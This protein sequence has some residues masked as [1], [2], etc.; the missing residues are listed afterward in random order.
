[1]GFFDD[2]YGG[3]TIYTGGAAIEHADS[4]AIFRDVHLFLERAKDLAATR[5][6]VIRENLKMSLLGSVMD[7]WLGE[8]STAEKRLVK[9][10]ASESDLSEWSRLLLDRFSTLPNVAIDAVL[11]ECYTF[12]DAA[13]QRELREYAQRI[14]RSVKDAGLTNIRNLV[15]IIYNGINLE[16][17]K[18]VSKPNNTTIINSFLKS[19]DSYKYK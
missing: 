9:Y 16:L 19:I 2:N 1:M 8:L 5:G 18:D 3:K 13:T 10:R 14:L 6:A 4:R 12:R 15:D 7:W 17:R 11:K